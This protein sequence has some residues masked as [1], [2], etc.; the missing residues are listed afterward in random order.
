MLRYHR[1]RKFSL[2]NVCRLGIL[3]FVDSPSDSETSRFFPTK[4]HYLT[5]FFVYV[6][7]GWMWILYIFMNFSTSQFAPRSRKLA[8]LE[9]SNL[10]ISFR[11]KRVELLLLF[12]VVILYQCWPHI[13]VCYFQMLFV[14]RTITFILYFLFFQKHS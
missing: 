2:L 5:H 10:I 8:R 13:E 3:R 12:D 4:Y 7:M 9:A 1:N 11:Y 14:F 6:C